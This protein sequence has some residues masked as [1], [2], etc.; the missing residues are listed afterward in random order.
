MG[1]WIHFFWKSYN[2]LYF[3]YSVFYN[4]QYDTQYHN[5]TNKTYTFNIEKKNVNRNTLPTQDKN[6]SSKCKTKLVVKE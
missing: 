3:S 1:T 6:E 4:T 2:N 5:T